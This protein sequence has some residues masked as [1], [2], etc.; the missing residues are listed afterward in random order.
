MKTSIM[1]HRVGCQEPLPSHG[2]GGAPRAP[3]YAV[4]VVELARLTLI[5]HWLF[6]YSPKK[7]IMSHEN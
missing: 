2:A 4:V 7:N 1:T 5:N 3:A 6:T